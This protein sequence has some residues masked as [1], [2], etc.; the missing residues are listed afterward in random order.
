MGLLAGLFVPRLFTS[1]KEVEPKTFTDSGITIT[2]TEDFEK[3][4]QPDFAAAYK[5]NKA[6]VLV[7]KEDFAY[8]P[9]LADYAIEEYGELFL[10]YNRMNDVSIMQSQNGLYYFE[11]EATNEE[12]GITYYYYCTLHRSEDAFWVV[13]FCTLAPSRDT[14]RPLFEQWSQTV[15]FP[16]SF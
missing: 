11:Y 14:M 6:M 4:S 12:N 7:V 16:K 10:N 2:L 3:D 15:T 9:Y 1:S 5:S 8:A 13:N